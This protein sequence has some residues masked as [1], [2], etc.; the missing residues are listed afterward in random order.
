MGDMS[1]TTIPVLAL[2]DGKEMPQ[3][4][5]GTYKLS[6]EDTIRVVRAGIDLGYR[7]IDTASLYGNEEAVG[8]A[9]ADAIS[10]GDVT[11]EDLFITTKAWNDEQGKDNIPVAFRRSLKKL[12]LDFLDLYLL[13]WPWPQRGLYNESFEAMA[14]VQGIGDVQCI[15]V[16]NFYEE[17]LDDLIATSGIIPAVNQVEMH[18][19]FSQPA[20]RAKHEELGIVSEAW[21]P[22]GRGVPMNNPDVKAIGASH[23]VSS[24]QVLLRYLLQLGVSVIP[25]TAS[26]DR[27]ADNLRALDF[28]LTRAEMDVLASLEVAPG[29][30]RL[31]K[32][33]RFHPGADQ[34]PQ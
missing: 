30:G 28:T 1:E 23:D 6:P 20:L 25:K 10:A 24:A 29:L 26:E 32:D 4:G 16:S 17:V 2:N 13:H 18:V 14:K 9:V 5:L 21:A 8:R 34:L 15:G 33:P 27:L 11:R 7:R 31:G 22:L 12:G 19:G 3:F